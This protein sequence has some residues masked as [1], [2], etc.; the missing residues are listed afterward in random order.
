MTLTSHP[1][2]LPADTPMWGLMKASADHEL[3]HA[4][5]KSMSPRITDAQR[6]QR[7]DTNPV[8][9]DDTYLDWLSEGTEAMFQIRRLEQT[10]DVSWRHPFKGSM[11]DSGVRVFAQP[12][13][14]G[15]IQCNYQESNH[16]QRVV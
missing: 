15:A 14:R 5:Q 3:Y 11:N 6:R 10:E 16:R 1:D 13:S 12:L 9:R 2:F 4:I 7:H 8:C